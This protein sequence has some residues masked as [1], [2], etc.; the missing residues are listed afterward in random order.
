M[1]GFAL[2]ATASAFLGVGVFAPLGQAHGDFK[3]EG[4]GYQ[5]AIALPKLRSCEKICLS[6]INTRA[7]TSTRPVTAK[8]SEI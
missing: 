1:R 6:M 8:T 5:G 2:E 4:R 3:S 7:A